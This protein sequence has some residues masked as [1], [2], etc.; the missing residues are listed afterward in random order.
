MAATNISFAPEFSKNEKQ[1]QAY[2]ELQKPVV[3]ELLYG[4]AKGGG[5]S[6]FGCNWMMMKAL[7]IIQQFNMPKTP[8][9]LALGVMARKQG[10]DFRKTT[11]ETWKQ[12]IPLELYR[13]NNQS[14]EIIICDRVKYFFGGFDN[15]ASINKFNSAE[16]AFFF[17]D[18]AEE[19]S[20][21]DV[22][23]L[24]GAMRLTIGGVTP[25]HKG[26][27][28]ANPAQCFLKE[29]FVDNPTPDR[30][31][32][33]AL[34]ADNPYLPSDYHN[35][36][37]DAFKHRPEM[38]QAYL[39]GS[40]ESGHD[41]A[42]IISSLSLTEAEGLSFPLFDLPVYIACDVAR[43]GDDETVIYVIQGTT[44]I[45]KEAYGLTDLFATSNKL[46]TMSRLYGNCT[47]VVDECGLGAGVVDALRGMGADVVGINANSKA[48]MRGNMRQHGNLRAAMWDNMAQMLASKSISFLQTPT[49]KSALDIE[50]RR[51]LLSPRY[52][53]K[54]EVMWI[55]EKDFI[56]KRLG[57]SPDHADAYLL[58]LYAYCTGMVKGTSSDGFDYEDL[59]AIQ[60]EKAVG[61]ASV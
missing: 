9:P 22:A 45:A 41:S 2:Y 28:T 17:V 48:P 23:L 57:R 36:L 33:R 13:I 38:L 37:K 26:L 44:P 60:R 3:R 53:Y 43:F 52:K 1:S 32:V 10:V 21:D 16:Y 47:I 5:K 34:P 29:E 25:P 59:D 42:Q 31:F 61:Y 55:E 20:A 54:G 12:T 19:L 46:F 14:S 7:E 39:Y 30:V 24:R 27:F 40:W 15:Q 51:D 8:N 11:L 49:S 4:G 35:T 18:Q 56:K 58:G 50:L 6:F